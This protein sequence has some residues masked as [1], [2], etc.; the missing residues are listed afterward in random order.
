[1]FS[2]QC[3]EIEWYDKPASESNP[4]KILNYKL[5]FRR[6]SYKNLRLYKS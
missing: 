2:D 3:L 6:V 5:R 1:M 4:I